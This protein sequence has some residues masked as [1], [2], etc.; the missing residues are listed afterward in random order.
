MNSGIIMKRK[1]LFGKSSISS[2]LVEPVIAPRIAA[3]IGSSAIPILYIMQAVIKLV[4]RMSPVTNRQM[5]S[6]LAICASAEKY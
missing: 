5:Y 2:V 3:I 1:S 6:F 4:A